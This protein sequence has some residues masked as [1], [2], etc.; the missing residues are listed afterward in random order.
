MIEKAPVANFLTMM[1]LDSSYLPLT[2]SMPEKV[3]TNSHVSPWLATLTYPLGSYLVL[4]AYFRHIQVTGQDNIPRTGPVII[5]PTH[6]SRWD[7]LM[8]PYSTGRLTT[9]RDLRFMVTSDEVKGIQGWFIRWLGGFA[10]NQKQPAISSLRHGVDLLKNQ[11][12]LV[13]FPEG[14]IFRDQQVHPLK[15]GLGRLAIQAELSHPGLN[16]KI[17]PMTIRYQP[18]IPQW[19][20]QVQIKIGTA[21]SVNSYCHGSSKQDAKKLTADLTSVLQELDQDD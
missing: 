3:A 5:A 7:A 13:I 20:S 15:P 12:M 4:P 21:L 16:V 8:V 10:I 18:T 9:G 14:N 19:G 1:T 2:S 11:E 6:R 17:V